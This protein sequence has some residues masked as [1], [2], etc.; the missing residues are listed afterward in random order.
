LNK[1]RAREAL[2]DCLPEALKGQAF[3]ET[4]RSE[5]AV[6]RWLTTLLKNIS[7]GNSQ[8][9]TTA[10]S[11][12]DSIADQSQSLSFMTSATASLSINDKNRT[13]DPVS[14]ANESIGQGW[15]K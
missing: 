2:R 12:D 15:G 14:F 9:V 11:I 7:D 4:L 13:N 6:Q 3:A 8:P 10:Q 5:E 1:Y